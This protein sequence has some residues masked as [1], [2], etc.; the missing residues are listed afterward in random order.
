MSHTGHGH[1]PVDGTATAVRL[2][3]QLAPPTSYP[4]RRTPTQIIFLRTSLHHHHESA[5]SGQQAY[6]QRASICQAE[7]DVVYAAAKKAAWFGI[8]V[9]EVSLTIWMT[10]LF[11][12]RVQSSCLVAAQFP[13]VW[14][15]Q[16][17]KSTFMFTSLVLEWRYYW[18]DRLK[19]ESNSFAVVKDVLTCGWLCRRMF[20]GISKVLRFSNF[21]GVEGMLCRALHSITQQPH[22]P[23]NAQ[24]WCTVLHRAQQGTATLFKV[25]REGADPTCDSLRCW[26]FSGSQALLPLTANQPPG[27]LPAAAPRTSPACGTR[28]WCAR[29]R[30]APG[31]GPNRRRGAERRGKAPMPDGVQC[32]RRLGQA[33]RAC[34]CR[35]E[36][37]PAKV[38]SRG[39]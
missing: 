1:R 31:L 8:R 27:P 24:Q 9:T 36:V 12:K 29:R 16:D 20:T 15:R 2:K 4:H 10:S 25:A 7:G 37:S 11:Q 34:Q 32:A 18:Q 14:L 21:E 26:S 38:S 33:G 39:R 30:W 28:G 23:Q 17:P 19:D 13:F 35:A 22:I 6:P 3:A 5:C